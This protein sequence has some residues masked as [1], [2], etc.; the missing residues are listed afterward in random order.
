MKITPA[1]ITKV[2]VLLNQLDLTDN[3]REIIYQLT[4]GRTTSAK[5]LTLDEARRLISSLEGYNPNERIKGAIF[6]LAYKAEII[7]GESE[8]DKRMNTAKLNA[9]I[10][11]R[12]AVKK[13]LNEMNYSELVKVQRQFE[14]MLK[15]I[16]ISKNRKANEAKAESAVKS[17]LSELNL[18]II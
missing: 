10:K 12:G 14:A 16:S 6:S 18:Q 5:D 8:T 13:H 17:L 2:H 1:Q 3:K 15:N 9:W 11:E 7:Y 4:E